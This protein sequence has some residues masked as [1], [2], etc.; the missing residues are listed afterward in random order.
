M[1][2]PNGARR[3]KADHPAL[4]ITVDEIAACA[5][6]CYAAGADGLHAHIRDS[7]GGH[8]L[9]AD[10]YRH[11]ISRVREVVP[12]MA[13]QITTEAVGIYDPD[14][15]MR[16]ALT[17]GA[18]MVSASIKEISGAGASK[19]RAFYQQAQTNG[20]AVQHILYS[21]EDCNLLEDTIGR[22]SVTDPRLEVIFVLGSYGGAKD[23]TLG[24]LDIFTSWMNKREVSPDWAVCAFGPAEVACLAKAVA[25]GGKCRVGFENSLVLSDGTVASNN[26]QKISDLLAVLNQ[27]DS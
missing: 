10:K 1:V 15:Q 5:K 18:D 7:A 17:S 13:I 19:A 25:C 4:P 14:A 9:D 27:A 3:T 23:A 8:L 21:L 2:A 20:I 6:E 26:A 24:D 22:E 12:E 11:L 16:I